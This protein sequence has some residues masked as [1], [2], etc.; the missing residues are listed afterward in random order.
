[1]TD[2]INYTVIAYLPPESVLPSTLFLEKD[3]PQHPIITGDGRRLAASIQEHGDV[4]PW[5]GQ[6][7]EYRRLVVTVDVSDWDFQRLSDRGAYLRL[8]DTLMIPIAVL[9]PRF[10]LDL[11]RR[12]FG[13]MTL[14]LAE[15]MPLLNTGQ[16]GIGLRLTVSI[17]GVRMDP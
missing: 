10:D 12:A 15:P 1:M 6:R 9:R 16:G 4:R 2:T 5:G 8:D 13:R 3:A 14:R 17:F 7:R 11:S